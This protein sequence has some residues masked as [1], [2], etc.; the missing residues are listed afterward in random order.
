MY[1]GYYFSTPFT[2]VHISYAHL[3]EL[4]D[5]GHMLLIERAE[6]PVM[7]VKFQFS[8]ETPQPGSAF[9]VRIKTFTQKSCM[10]A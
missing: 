10:L 2:P 6:V 9:C 4:E 8:K 7:V 1:P 3:G 5:Q